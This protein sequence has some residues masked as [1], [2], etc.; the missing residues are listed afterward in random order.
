MVKIIIFIILLIISIVGIVFSIVG[1]I[2]NREKE[3]NG[4][5]ILSFFIP[6]VGLIIYAVNIGK[7]DKLAKSCVKSALF[8]IT[9]ALCITL[10]IFFSIGILHTVYEEKVETVEGNRIKEGSDKAKEKY[11]EINNKD[12]NESNKNY[13]DVNSALLKYK[14]DKI[15]AVDGRLTGKIWYIEISFIDGTSEQEAKQIIWDFFKKYSFDR[16]YDYNVTL[17]VNGNEY[18]GYF[19]GIQGNNV[20]WSN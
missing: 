2:K 13:D 14:N 16:Q 4:A 11:D 5:N 12:N 17:I 18:I 15:K 6:L 19:D 10:S 1:L 3:Y 20:I 7:N 8:G 9:T